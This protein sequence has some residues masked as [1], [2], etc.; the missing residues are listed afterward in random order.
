M[1]SRRHA[2]QLDLLAPAE[3]VGTLLAGEA[4][5]VPAV[6]AVADEIA[7]AADLIAAG[8]LAGGRWCSWGPARPAGSRCGEAAELPGTFGIDPG[9]AVGRMAGLAAGADGAEDDTAPGPR[10]LAGRAGPDDVLIAVAA[11]GLDPY[12]LRGRRAGR[13][14]RRCRDRGHAGAPLGRLAE[15]GRSWSAVRRRGVARLPG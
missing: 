14:R 10:G 4:R 9:A 3:I 11:S 1:V 13:R 2:R 12:T 8:W 6:P 7:A 5:V 15:R